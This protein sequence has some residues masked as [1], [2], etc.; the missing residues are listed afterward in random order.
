S[1][2]LWKASRTWDP[3]GLLSTLPAVG[4]SMLGILAGRWIG[5]ER[6]LADRIAGLF[7]AGAL[8]IVAGSIWHWVFP[9]NKC[10]WTSSYAVCRAGAACVTLATCMWLVDLLEVRRW[11]RPLVIF[12]VNPLLAF[13]GSGMMARL[14]YG[15]LRVHAADGSNPSVQSI[16]YRHL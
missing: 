1:A 2:H 12:G 6:P 8:G 13:V 15:L 3:E 14:I 11:T 7:A 5:S 9:I 4:T 16:V 10:L